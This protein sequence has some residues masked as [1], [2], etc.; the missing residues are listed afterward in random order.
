MN[1]KVSNLVDPEFENAVSE[2]AEEDISEP[3]KLESHT[4]EENLNDVEKLLDE[5]QKLEAKS[6]VSQ[7][8]DDAPQPKVI[9]RQEMIDD[10]I[11]N[12]FLKHGLNKSLEAFQRE[13]YEISQKGKIRLDDQDK[14]PDIKVKNQHLEEKIGKLKKE[15]EQAKVSADSAKATWDKLR[16]EKEYHMQHHK[17][18]LSE[19]EQLFS[20]IDKLKKLHLEYEQKYEQLKSKYEAA[21]KE[22][23]LIK[24]ERDRYE[25]TATSL[26]QTLKKLEKQDL[27]EDEEDQ[28][29]GSPLKTAADTKKSKKSR[30]DETTESIPTK[31]PNGQTRIPKDDIT[32]PYLTTTFEAF[33]TKNLNP[34]RNFKCHSLAVTALAIHPRKPFIATGGNDFLWKVWSVPGGEMIIQGESHK[35]WISGLDF[36]PTGTNMV[37]CS[38][39]STVKIWDFLNVKCSATFKT[40]TQPVLGVSY[41]YT[42]DFVI[43]GNHLLIKARWTKLL[44][45]LISTA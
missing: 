31:G 16:K 18:V 14:V 25:K 41:H 26:N 19:K 11:R 12:F 32:N 2:D 37:T 27:S 10:Y 20:D 24:M 9:Q 5:T 29:K 13:W 45:C 4:V 17:R 34:T 6:V 44:D 8:K 7:V 38:G 23:M 42:G 30:K 3:S 35:D 28:E 43:S 21:T 22:K 1:R 36:N 40:H 39:D 15:L 33:P